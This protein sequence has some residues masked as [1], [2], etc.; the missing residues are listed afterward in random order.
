M[1][2]E[3]FERIPVG[4]DDVCVHIPKLFIDV[5]GEFAQSRGIEPAKLTKG[6]GIERMSVPDAHEDAATMGA[7]SLLKLLQKNNIEPKHVGKIYIGT[8]SGVD[9]SKA[10]GTYILGMM[11]R[12]Y[13]QG[14]FEECATVEFKF[15]CI[16]TT[17][18]LENVSYW[19]NAL[20]PND[21]RVGIV[22]ASDI[23]KYDLNSPGEYTQGAGSVAMLVK[24]NPRILAFEPNIGVFTKN[25]NDFYRPIGESTAVVHGKHSNACYMAA[26]KS[27]LTSYER[28]A[29]RRGVITLKNGECLSDHIS[30][31]I[32]HIPYPRM[33]EYA[34]AFI[35][36]HEWRELPRWK[37]IEKEIGKEPQQDMFEDY[38]EFIVADH[39]YRRKFSKTQQFLD[40]F[41]SKVVAST[42]LSRQIGNIYTGSLY[43]GLMSLLEPDCK[44]MP[45][46]RVGFGSYGSGCEAIVFSGI[47]PEGISTRTKT[48]IWKQLDQRKEITVA[49][50]ERLHEGD[51][52]ESVIPP[53]NEFALTGFDKY[54]YR[55]Y[56]YIK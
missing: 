19:V 50:Y 38:D 27:A 30:H 7:M 44:L 31:M 12:V 3:K 33:A 35:F 34:S 26:M 10:I 36:K 24:K 2:N 53:R 8:E 29:I 43:L 49:D 45:G 18:A 22:I 52:V 54:A 32:F 14:S 9:E 6:I 46:Q 37:V 15:A 13:G 41:K 48:D 20:H 11:E 16:G 51:S 47:V 40:A 4:I 21:P 5:T 28:K 25:E 23:A 56:D 39:Q 55:Q 42:M 1:S 17:H